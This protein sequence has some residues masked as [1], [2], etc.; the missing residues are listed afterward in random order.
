MTGQ[1][2][3]LKLVIQQTRKTLS[4]LKKEGTKRLLRFTKDAMISIVH[5]E[6]TAVSLAIMLTQAKDDLLVHDYKIIAKRADNGESRKRTSCF[7]RVL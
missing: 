3:H 4:I 7:F 5:D 1:A 2:N 6:T